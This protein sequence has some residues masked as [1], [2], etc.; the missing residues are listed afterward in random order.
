V[1]DFEHELTQMFQDVPDDG[2]SQR[3]ANAAMLR[4]DRED[5]R[6]ALVLTIAVAAGV[7]VTGLAILGSGAIG[8][9]RDLLMQ[10]LTAE[11]RFGLALLLWPAAAAALAACGAATLRPGRAL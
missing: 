8:A 3:L 11:P 9:T 6:R 10:A 2:L 1:A 5:N 4:I 7:G